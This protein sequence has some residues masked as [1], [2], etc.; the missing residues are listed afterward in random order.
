MKDRILSI[1]LT[2]ALIILRVLL[3]F[4]KQHFLPILFFHYLGE[5]H[6]ELM[7]RL[8]NSGQIM[9]NFFL[10]KNNTSYNTAT[11]KTNS[12]VESDTAVGAVATGVAPLSSAGS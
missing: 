1:L 10:Q 8:L 9:G 6:G 5:I 7:K 4:L 3:F 11:S 2:P 12:N